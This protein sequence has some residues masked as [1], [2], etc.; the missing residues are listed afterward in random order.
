MNSLIAAAVARHRTVLSLLFLV[1]VAGWSTF[2]TVPKESNPDIP[3]PVFY[4][5][6]VHDG[7]S[8]EDG[9]RLIARPLERQLKSLDGLKEMESS[10]SEGYVSVVLEFVAGLDSTNVLA[11]I[12]DAVTL[13]R[14]KL[15]SD[16]EEPTVKEITLAEENP[17][18]TVNLF[19]DVPERALSQY[20]RTLRDKLESFPEIL[21]VKMS[22][23]REEVL[24]I[25]V[26]PKLM[27]SYDISLQSLFNLVSNNN[28]LVAAGALDTGNGV[29]AIKVPGIIRDFNDVLDLPLKVNEDRVVRFSDVASIRS[30]FKDATSY[31]RLNGKPTIGLDII[32]RPGEN[33]IETVNKVKALVSDELEQLPL[34]IDAVFTGDAS[35]EIEQMLGD[36]V[37]NVFSAVILV[38][39]IILAFLGARSALLVGIAIPGSFLMGILMLSLFDVTLNIV[40]LFALIMSVGMLVDGAIVVTEYADR[41]MSEGLDKKQ[42]YTLAA[43]RMAWPILA[44]TATTLAAFMPLL[45]WPDMMG[46]FMKYLPM[47]LIA[48]LFASLIMALI[49]VATLGSL[50]G[51]PRYIS[52][53]EKRNTMASESGN[54]DDITGF[55]A[56]YLK[57]LRWA[58]SHPLIVLLISC[59]VLVGSYVS[60]IGFGPGLKF[61][62]DI[63][64]DFTTIEV[65]AV[66]DLSINEKDNIV[67]TVENEIGRLADAESIY[68]KT[69]T[70]RGSDNIGEIRLN[71]LDWDERR[72]AAEVISEL[73]KKIEQLPGI[74]A[75]FRQFKAGPTP[76]KA[77][78]IRL[79]SKFPDLLE[80]HVDKL[81]TAM[82]SVDGL[83]DVEDSR[84]SPGIEW[85]LVVDRSKAAQYGADITQVGFVIPLVTNGVKIANY[86][87]DGA[88]DE[89]DIRVRFPEKFR[90]LDQLEELRLRTNYGM[91]PLSNFVEKQPAPKIDIISRIDAQRSLEVSAELAPGASLEEALTELESKIDRNAW[92]PR[93]EYVLKGENEE[94]QKS[95]AFLGRA[96]IIAL[97]VMAIILV[98][99]FN[100]FYQTLLILSAVVFSTAGVFLGLFIMNKPFGVIMSGI[101]VISLAGIIVNNN[102]VLIDTYNVLRKEGFALQEAVLRAGLQRL[103]PVLLTTFT[104]VMGLMP[105]VL[106]MNL[107]FLSREISIGA[108]S[109]QWWVQ[110]ASAVAGGLT[111]AT[112]LTLIVTPSLLILGARRKA[113][114]QP[115]THLQAL[116]VNQN[117][118]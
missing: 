107:D 92:D 12:R 18:V 11:D 1:I 23:D 79:A 2:Q 24:E 64:P 108:P 63:E 99:Q 48:V 118:N 82:N 91:I 50:I 47:T 106:Q 15:P 101:G 8:P 17:A 112:L 61:F 31:A 7:I 66:G 25:I 39:I 84:P 40:V 110:L 56:N 94:Q 88:D 100:S 55:S 67:R 104:T 19:G 95:M 96:F 54:L 97:F 52:S 116:P 68:V 53:A 41:K 13:A 45:F 93:V 78:E 26:D 73:R 117:A 44:S 37:N 113:D 98:T 46:E 111:F 5:S 16:S 20:A 4:I 35:E 103:R 90:H 86:R 70:K 87:P 21:E 75:K 28:R 22:G 74:V 51:K 38:A 30:T 34:G 77:V 85:S 49:G 43:Q 83:T 6:V 69:Q 109:T 102:I 59:C 14:D 80:P 62:P 89:V 33:T 10:A 105:M 27:E 32:K 57:I 71:F 81:V 36:L 72:P 3:I 9:E 65:R 76:G 58:T 42:A 29:F 114:N 60:F 115:S